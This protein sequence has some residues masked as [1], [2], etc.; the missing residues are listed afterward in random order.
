MPVY[1][2]Y[3]LRESRQKSFRWAPHISGVT[4]VNPKNYSDDGMAEAST[5]YAAWFWLRENGRSLEV[6][7]LLEDPKGE[8]SICKYVGFE[9]ANWILP[10]EAVEL[11]SGEIP[12]SHSG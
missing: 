9:E 2:I 6:G 8:L 7:D 4:T 12:A 11:E 5:P 3:R 1:R 10:E